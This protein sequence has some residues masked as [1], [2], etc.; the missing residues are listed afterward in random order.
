MTISVT[1]QN[2]GDSIDSNQ[3]IL[4]A[5]WLHNTTINIFRIKITHVYSW[6]HILQI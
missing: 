5:V 4:V 6:Y 1:L 3:Y 2:T